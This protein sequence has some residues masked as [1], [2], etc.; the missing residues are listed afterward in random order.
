MRQIK[1]EH[2]D[3]DIECIN[4]PYQLIATSKQFDEIRVLNIKFN[5]LIK[6]DH[7]I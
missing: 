5:V 3:F 7:L 1:F 4:I 2:F 6:T